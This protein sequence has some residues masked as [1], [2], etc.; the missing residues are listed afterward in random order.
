[1]QGFY[2]DPY[3]NT[4]IMGV[5]T[6]LNTLTSWN[7]IYNFDVNSCDDHNNWIW[8]QQCKM[9]IGPNLRKS[10]NKVCLIFR[11]NY[12]LLRITSE[13]ENLLIQFQTKASDCLLF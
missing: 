11:I 4:Y 2:G 8:M 12:S 9:Y 5:H 6:I 13:K 7:S 3:L 10:F 1:M